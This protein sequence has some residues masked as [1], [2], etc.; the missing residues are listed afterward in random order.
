MAH[1]GTQWL[2]APCEAPGMHVAAGMSKDAPLQRGREERRG[3]GILLG[4]LPPPAP[5]GAAPAHG[6]E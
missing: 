5:T 1:R 4:W 6:Q 3:E 2:N